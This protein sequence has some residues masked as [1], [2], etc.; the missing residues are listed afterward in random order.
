MIERRFTHWQPWRSRGEIERL[1]Y[2][3]V[4]AIARTKEGLSG[5][6][7]ELSESIIYFG[8]T[9]ALSGITGR[10]RKFDNTISGRRLSHGGADRVRHRFP[11]YA[12][13]ASRLYVAVAQFPCD[14]GSS[15]P[16]D[17]RKMGEVARALS[18]SA[19]R[20]TRRSL[21]G[22]RHAMTRRSRRSSAGGWSM[23]ANKSFDT[24]AQVRPCAAR[25]RLVC[26][27][28]VRRSAS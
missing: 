5:A 6:P 7:F 1:H 10:L 21:A 12:H 22:S 15:L 14:P 24:D 2:P 18:I 3:G 16:G 8:M 26:A 11:G 19:S 4:Y 13:L 9:N 23:K 20:R 17:L 28:Q 25:T 27:G